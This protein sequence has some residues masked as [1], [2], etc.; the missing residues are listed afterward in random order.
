MN[1]EDLTHFENMFKSQALNELRECNERTRAYGLSLSETQITELIDARFNALRDTGR[2]E[3]GQGILK[4]LVEVFCDSPYITQDIYQATLF[5]LQDSFY[6]Y[7]NESHER[8]SD[9]ALIA[10]MKRYFNEFCRD[11]PDY[12]SGVSF[13]ELVRFSRDGMTP[14]KDGSDRYE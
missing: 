11:D 13:E 4:K 9:D 14:G 5:E 10:M 8:L 3:F 7:K 6:Y 2:V 1:N 12:F